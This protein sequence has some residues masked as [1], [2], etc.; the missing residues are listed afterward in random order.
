MEQ[1]VEHLDLDRLS[2]GL[3]HV[4]QSPGD[5]GRVAMIVRRPAADAR[6]VLEEGHL[7]LVHGLSGDN[8]LAR[9]S[10]LTPD[11]AAHPEAQLTLMNVRVADLVA[12]GPERRVLA[13]DQL[14]VDLDL[15]V[16]NLPA[17]T[18][19]ALGA[20]VL[21]V[22]PKPHLGC[23]KFSARFGVDALKLVNAPIGRELRLRGL[24]ARV[25]VPGTVRP[26]DEIRKLP[27]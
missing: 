20:A 1:T 24:N 13:G 5:R 25:V 17:G 23:A 4:R 8:W 6:E 7:D 27:A 3:D 11:G 12:G 9:G 2:A 10:S 26:G 21:E 19:L 15:S 18:R 14:F 16:A 22:T